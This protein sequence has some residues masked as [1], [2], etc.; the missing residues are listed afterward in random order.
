MEIFGGFIQHGLIYGRK[1]SKL[2]YEN[3]VASSIKGAC[4]S[5]QFSL[6]SQRKL[7]DKIDKCVFTH[8]ALAGKV[9]STNGGSCT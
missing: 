9:K 8:L 5:D 4:Y 6:I 1:S 3:W 7:V 2:T